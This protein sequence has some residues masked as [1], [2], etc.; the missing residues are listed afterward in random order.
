[1]GS[2]YQET[3]LRGT[4]VPPVER[5]FLSD[6]VRRSS[7]VSVQRVRGDPGQ[8]EDTHTHPDPSHRFR[9]TLSLS[10]TTEE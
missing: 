10:S 8:I 6:P 9:P 4:R 2:L 1:M 5:P 3:F 7:G